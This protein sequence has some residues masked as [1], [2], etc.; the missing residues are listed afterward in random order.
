MYVSSLA[1]HMHG[2][3]EIT[4][5]EPDPFYILYIKATILKG[6]IA[7]IYEVFIL[8]TSLLLL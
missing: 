4:F 3:P 2:F 7:L 6:D 5:P 8:F 1:H